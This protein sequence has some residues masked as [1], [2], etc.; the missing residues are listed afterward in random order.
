MKRFSIIL[1][2]II[3]LTDS[4]SAYSPAAVQAYISKY[5][6]T[7]LQN[8]K[9]FGIP[10]TIILD[11]EYSGIGRRDKWPD[12]VVKQS[13]RNQGRFQ[14]DRPRTLGLGRRDEEKP[15]QML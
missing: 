15:V 4:L 10:A 5:K 7:A 3:L 1:L 8:E 2:L 6:A 12:P 9:E 13:F 11:S 14:M